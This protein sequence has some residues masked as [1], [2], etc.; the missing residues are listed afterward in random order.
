MIQFPGP[1]RHQSPCTLHERIEDQIQKDKH[2]WSCIALVPSWRGRGCS[3][4]E[5]KKISVGIG[6]DIVQL[7]SGITRIFFG[8]A[9]PTSRERGSPRTFQIGG[10]GRTKYTFGGLRYFFSFADS[11]GRGGHGPPGPRGYATGLRLE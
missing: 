11:S 2:F 8:G 3:S 6:E 9:K 10:G 4:A 1:G 7:Y 5:K